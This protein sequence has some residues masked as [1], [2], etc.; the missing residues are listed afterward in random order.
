MAK[1]LLKTHMRGD[2]LQQ[3]IQNDQAQEALRISDDVRPI[4]SED[5]S[6]QPIKRFY[7]GDDPEEAVK[8]THRRD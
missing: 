4:Q 3:Q 6:M 5:M 8:R 7:Q 2:K 1:R